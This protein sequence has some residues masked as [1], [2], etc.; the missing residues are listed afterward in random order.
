MRSSRAVEKGTAGPHAGSCLPSRATEHG[1][2]SRHSSSAAAVLCTV[3]TQ[4]PGEHQDPEL[5]SQSGA[6]QQGR[7]SREVRR[8]S[9]RRRLED[10]RQGF[11]RWDPVLAQ[12]AASKTQATLPGGR[13]QWD[14]T[15]RR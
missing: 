6:L 5:V 14:D 12:T 7:L 4:V 15:I 2:R 9:E 3:L 1:G 8:R 11:R 13:K 10:R